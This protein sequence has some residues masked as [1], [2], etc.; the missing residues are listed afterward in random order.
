M[1]ISS[2]DRSGESAAVLRHYKKEESRC[3]ANFGN[4]A[5][6]NQESK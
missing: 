4:P 2:E 1:R 6:S 3:Q 5:A